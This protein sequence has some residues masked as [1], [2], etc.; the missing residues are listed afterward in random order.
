MTNDFNFGLVQRYVDGTASAKDMLQLNSQLRDSPEM[1]QEFIELLNLDSA[2]S[3]VCEPVNEEEVTAFEVKRPSL[4]QVD[5]SEADSPPA[6]SSNRLLSRSLFRLAAVAACLTLLIGGTWWWHAS[7]QVWATVQNRIGFGGLKEGIELR[8]ELH[9]IDAGVVQLVTAYGAE[10]VIEAPAKFQFESADRLK[11]TRGRLSASVPPAA[12]GF[13]VMTP[14]GEAV[15]LGTRFGVDVRG[16][17]PAEIHV[18]EGE[19]IAKASGA[20]ASD[21]LYEGDA[22]RMDQGASASRELR[23]S[24]FIQSAEM[25]ELTPHVTSDQ[26]RRAEEYVTQLRRDP[27]LIAMLDFESDQLPPGVFHIA[28]GRWPRSRAPEFID[29]GDHMRLDAGGDREWPQLTL[30]AWVRLDQVGAPYQSLLHTDGWEST[31]GQVHWMVTRHTTMRLAL[32]GN[33]LAPDAEELEGYPDSRTP[34]L[35]KQGRWVHLATVYDATARTVRFYLNGDFDKETRQAIAHPARL[36]AAQIGN[37][38]RHDRKLSGRVDEL[39]IF[40]RTLSDTEIQTLYEA[41][42]PYR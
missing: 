28:Q 24:A 5:H 4:T 11:L 38:D 33:T 40:G 7:Q 9:E 26:R 31:P 17:G 35:P 1:R 3:I 37:W 29:V 22:V 12:T 18:F 25:S 36:G 19:V 20:S 39:F 8:G 27:A 16:I 14:S 23:S 41:G 34:V 32:A 21:N 30:A 15:D 42:N 2:L 13:T 10:I 6:D